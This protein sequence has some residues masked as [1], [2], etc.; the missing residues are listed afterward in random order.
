MDEVLLSTRV[1]DKKTGLNFYIGRLEI[2]P[3]YVIGWNIEFHFNNKIKTIHF[4]S[5]EEALDFCGFFLTTYLDKKIPV[6]SYPREK[7]D[8]IVGNFGRDN[9]GNLNSI[10]QV[11]LFYLFIENGVYKKVYYEV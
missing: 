11:R 2:L 1:A 8:F 7:I 5:E 3:S 4:G 6:R 9:F 10:D